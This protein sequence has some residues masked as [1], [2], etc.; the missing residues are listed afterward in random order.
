MSLKNRHA[1]VCGA[2]RGIG[3]ATAAA[4][5][6]DGVAVTLLARN[7]EALQKVIQNLP[8]VKDRQHD[9]I[10]ADVNDTEKLQLAV[11]EK[12][13]AHNVQILINNSGGPAPGTAND[14][15]PQAYA[16]AFRQHLIADQV[17]M[18]TVLPGMKTSGYGRIINIISTSV[19]EPIPGL[20]VSNTIRAAVAAWAKTLSREL[21]TH[22][23][24]VNNV[25]PGYTATERLDEIF[26]HQAKRA[27]RTLDEI[28]ALRQAE[29]P[30][31]RFAEPAEIAAA[32]AFLASPAASYINGVNL[33]VDGGRSR[34][35]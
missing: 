2:S 35:Y 7:A 18:Q 34:G 30:L 19:K 13:A 33:P 1:L 14:A 5:A 20:G 25:L 15:D 4:L 10:V 24:T 21:G 8:V 3:A 22:G 17:L 28:V 12:T 6:R 11:S 32:I 23:I 9:F 29:V 31:Q 16:E 27:G 26:R